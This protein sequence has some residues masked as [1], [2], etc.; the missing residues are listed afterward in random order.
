LFRV[1]GGG[2][3]RSCEVSKQHKSD[4]DDDDNGGWID[5]T[6]STHTT[7]MMRKSAEKATRLDMEALEPLVILSLN[8][9]LIRMKCP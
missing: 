6:V 7:T 9:F 8:E 2:G 1:K 5:K 3:K 4:V